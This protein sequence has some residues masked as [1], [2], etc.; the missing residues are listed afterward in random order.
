MMNNILC[1]LFRLAHGQDENFVTESFVFICNYLL[2]HDEPIGRK[3]LQFLC[4]NLNDP[5]QFNAP[6]PAI[7]I[8]T[9]WET[10]NGTPDIRISMEHIDW[11]YVNG[12]K[13][14]RHM[15]NMIFKAVERAKIPYS[16]KTGRWN[17]WLGF[18]LEGKKF[19][20]AVGY[21]RPEIIRFGVS[22]ETPFDREAFKQLGRGRIDD[23]GQF[24]G[25]RPKHR[26]EPFLFPFCR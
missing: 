8:T 25:A 22:S 4:C 16:G 18:Y 11:E 13:A 5:L 23:Y 14:F 21:A 26:R 1:K 7:T 3:L 2:D 12:A 6:R 10:E 20:I 15:L 19:V 9:Q 24:L 17:E